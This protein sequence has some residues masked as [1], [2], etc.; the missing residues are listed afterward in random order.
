MKII[1]VIPHLKL[2][3]AEIMCENL[4]YEL[5]K[6]NKV[7]V[8]SL[9]SEETPI[10]TRLKEKGIPVIFMNKN[11]GFDLKCIFNLRR[12]IKKEKPDIIHT[13]LYS[14]KYVFF[15]C[16]FNKIRI[17]HTIHNVAQKECT[18]KDYQI[19][20]FIFK[21]KIAI[22]VALSKEIQET[23]N[24]YYNINYDDIPIVFNGIDLSKC[25]VKSKYNN[26]DCLKFIH[27]GR[28]FSQKNHT[29]LVEAFYE[30]NKKFK[31]S[32][33]YLIGIG[34][35]LEEI[36]KLVNNLE[37]EDNVIFLGQ[38]NSVYTYLFDSDVFIM[39]SLYEGIPMALIE[40]M[41][42]ALPIIV[43]NVG[44]ISDMLEDK[45]SALFV[46]PDKNSILNAMYRITGNCN[47][48]KK[49][50]R[51]AFLNSNNFSSLSMSNNY[52]NLYLKYS[53]KSNRKG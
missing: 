36:K 28:F 46:T 27:V 24:K 11:N 16:I 52:F 1:Q 2:G 5:S 51:N 50:A 43:S 25:I 34:E 7:I 21:K 42:T 17:I 30:Y 13:H 37:L 39:P 53:Y 9:Y 48:Q 8:V 15:S 35:K 38:Q 14:L 12:L 29:G 19:N 49:I 41:G 22:P 4:S 32:K 33:L 45:K 26:T 44:G 10:T 18:K 3:G 23:I 47:L 40:A 31:N 6:K 20:K